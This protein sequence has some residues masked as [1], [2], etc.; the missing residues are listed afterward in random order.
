MY[1]DW[2]KNLKTDEDKTKFQSSLMSGKTALDRLLEILQEYENSLERSEI[3]PKVFDT[4][5][6]AYLQAYKN[7]YRA[8]LSKIKTLINLDDQ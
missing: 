6:W 4:P 1:L 7:G 5:N 8:C 2:T 3:D